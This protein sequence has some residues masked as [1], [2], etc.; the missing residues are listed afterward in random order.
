MSR[1][2]MLPPIVYVPQAK[3]RKIENRKSRIQAGAAKQT[4]ET[5]E[6]HE[7]FAAGRPAPA[8]LKP[9][10]GNQPEIEGAEDKPQRQSRLSENTL[11]MLLQAQELE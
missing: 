1:H 6:S 4:D 2:H 9:L 5:T 11:K 3:P 8:G 7:A 10:P